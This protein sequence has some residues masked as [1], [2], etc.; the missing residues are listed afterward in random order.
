MRL[1]GNVIIDS[2]CSRLLLE[3]LWFIEFVI[4]L[5]LDSKICL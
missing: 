3:K 5:Y 2:T 1:I 4:Y